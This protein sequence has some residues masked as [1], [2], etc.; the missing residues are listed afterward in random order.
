MSRSIRG[1]MVLALVCL[2]GCVDIPEGIHAVEHVDMRRYLGTWYEI[3]RLENHFEKGLEQVSAS[4]SLNEDGSIRVLNR[5]YE[6]E[7]NAWHDAEG[8]AYPVEGAQKGRLKVTF[9]WPF[10]GAYNIIFLDDK[11]YQY[12]VVAGPDRSWL[13]ILSRT[14]T[15]D[16]NLL[17]TLLEK[18]KALGFDTDSLVYPRQNPGIPAS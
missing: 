17:R 9:F 12:S 2:A 14:P 6:P 8:E 11:D 1:M 7:S 3:A 15:M 13:W 4:Y 18:T 10:Y 5:G 16:G